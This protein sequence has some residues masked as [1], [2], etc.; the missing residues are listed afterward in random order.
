[1]AVLHESSLTSACFSLHED[2]HYDAC[3]YCLGIVQA[4]RALI[5]VHFA[6]AQTVNSQKGGDILW[7]ILGQVTMEQEDCVP[8]EYLPSCH[9][10]QSDFYTP[11]R[12]IWLC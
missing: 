1:M 10:K 5:Y 12:I 6:A 3:L 7:K 2:D 11:G 4:R 8:A 9:K